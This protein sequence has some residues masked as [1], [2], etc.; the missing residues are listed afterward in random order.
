MYWNTAV[1]KNT[2]HNT[3]SAQYEWL[4]VAGGDVND[5]AMPLA[6][7]IQ[8]RQRQKQGPQ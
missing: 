7:R 8:I 4:K 1:F 2:A 5:V 6:A 3:A